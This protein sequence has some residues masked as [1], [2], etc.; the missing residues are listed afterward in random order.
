MAHPDANFL[1]VGSGENTYDFGSEADQLVVDPLS[2]RFLALWNSRA[3]I[4][5]EVFGK[6]FHPVPHDDVRTWKDYD[7]FY[8]HFFQGAGA[9]ATGA[10]KSTEGAK[11]EE[12]AEKGVKK[13]KPSKYKWG[14]VVAENFPPGEQGVAEVKE[15]LSRVKG[16]LVEMPLLFLIK[17][18]IAKEGMGLNAFTEVVYT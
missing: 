11:A 5:T 14:H 2:D 1:P 13:A 9:D 10:A 8:S 17:E 18:D 7:A 3:R 16:T 4:N 12:G 6:V 15:L